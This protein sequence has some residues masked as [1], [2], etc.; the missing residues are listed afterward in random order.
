[1]TERRDVR[2]PLDDM[3]ENLLRARLTALDAAADD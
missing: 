2:L 1:M 3:L